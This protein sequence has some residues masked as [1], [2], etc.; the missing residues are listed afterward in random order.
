MVISISYSDTPV[1]IRLQAVNI[2][3][4]YFFLLVI[5]YP[6]TPKMPFDSFYDRLVAYIRAGMI[7]FASRSLRSCYFLLLPQYFCKQKQSHGISAL[8]DLTQ[9]CHYF[10]PTFLRN[11][12]ANSFTFVRNNH[13]KPSQDSGRTAL[14]ICTWLAH[15]NL[16][17]LYLL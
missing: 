11:P 4:F 3:T 9:N 7:T 2:Y 13:N 14:W 16:A 15:S 1:I 10:K 5:S 17:A 12:T 6:L 8:F